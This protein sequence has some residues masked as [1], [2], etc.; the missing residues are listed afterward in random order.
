V[1]DLLWLDGKDLRRLPLLERKKLLRSIIPSKSSCV[2]YVRY[3]NG[4]AKK[5]F[6]LVKA[7]DLEGLVVKGKDRK[8]YAAH[9]MVQGPKSQ[10]PA[11]GPR[12]K[13]CFSGDSFEVSNDCRIQ[14]LSDLSLCAAASGRSQWRLSGACDC[15]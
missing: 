12:G 3:S 15:L 8:I 5:L 10:L 7:S 4:G 11:R 6:A 14:T 13:I 2:G 1:F 9:H